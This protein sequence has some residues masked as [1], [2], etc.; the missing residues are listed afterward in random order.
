[1]LYSGILELSQDFIIETCSV[2]HV[3]H[4]IGVERKAEVV[5]FYMLLVYQDNWQVY[6][7]A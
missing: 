2:M 6:F 4:W 1:M 7:A 5:V 3:K